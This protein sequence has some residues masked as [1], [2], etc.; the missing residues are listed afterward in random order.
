M[1]KLFAFVAVLGMLFLGASLNAAAQDEAVLDAVSKA[2][3]EGFI[4]PILVGDENKIK[5][6]SNEQKIKS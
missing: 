2:H 6:I 4:E 5:Q 3:N 1:K